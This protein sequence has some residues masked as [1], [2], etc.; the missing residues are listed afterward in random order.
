MFDLSRAGV[1]IPY[2]DLFVV[3]DRYA[4][5][6]PIFGH[7]YDFPVPNGVH[8]ACAGPWLKPSLD[9]CGWTDVTRGA[10]IVRQALLAFKK[11]LIGLAA[12]PVNNFSLIDTQGLLAAGDWANELHP[13]PA[14][15]KT[16]A[17]RFVDALR[18]KFPGRI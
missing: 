2:R 3:R 9:Y 18:A 12:D 11:L 10:A 1:P 17:G 8:P 5:G 7:C 13:Y 4:A 6:V 15:F 16:I 14:G